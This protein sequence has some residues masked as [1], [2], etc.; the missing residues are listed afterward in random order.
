MM[1]AAQKNDRPQR[2]ALRLDLCEGD[3]AVRVFIDRDQLCGPGPVRATVQVTRRDG[4][5][6]EMTLPMGA[7][8]A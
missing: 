5:M 7:S 8:G 3:E 6:D 4:S 2:L 1:T